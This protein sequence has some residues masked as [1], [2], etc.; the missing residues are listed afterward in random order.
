M[1]SPRTVRISHELTRRVGLMRA[2]FRTVVI[3]GLL[4][5]P[6]VCAATTMML[7]LDARDTVHGIQHAHLQ[8][9]VRSGPVTLSYPKWIPGE[10]A[11][12][13]A[14]TEVLNLRFRVGNRELPWRRDPRD[15]FTFHL[16][17]SQGAQH[18]DV[19]LDFYS[20]SQPFGAGFAKSPNATSKL[21]VLLFNQF[22]LYPSQQSTSSIRVV[23]RIR[24][25]DEW[26]YD[27]ALTGPHK[28]SGIIA[29]P[30]VSLTR[31]VDSPLLSARYLRTVAVTTGP[32]PTRLTIA[33][34]RASELE[35]SDTRIG[36]LRG[37][38]SETTS[39]FGGPHYD[40]YVWL[41][42]LS[43]GL[44]HD[45]TEHQDS[46]DIRES[47]K[48][49]QNP[50]CSVDIVLLPHEF[51]HSWNGKFRRPQDLMT[52][53]F[54][55]PMQDDLLW[56]YE[57]LTRYYGDFVLA[58]RSGLR[59]QQQAR[60][61]VAFVA[62]QMEIGRPGRAWRPLVDT[63]VTVPA[64]GDAPQAWTAARRGNDYYN[65]MLLIWLEADVLIRTQT[66]GNRS[67][68][69]FCR[70]FFASENRGYD[71]SDVIAAMN[72]TADYDWHGFFRQ[73]VY[74][75]APKAPLDG[76]MLGGWK[77]TF[78]DD[79]N[80]FLVSLEQISGTADFSSS[81][82]IW[83]GADGTVKDVVPA[84]PA[85]LAGIAPGSKILTV[86]SEV[87]STNG[88]RA[89]LMRAEKNPEELEMIVRRGTEE[90]C[91]KL[92]YGR[93]LRYPHLARN[94]EAKDALLQ[95]LSPHSPESQGATSNPP[96]EAGK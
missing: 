64:Y 11:P 24:L 31:L 87:F 20:P 81:L 94:D 4:M 92:R 72:A 75:L 6:T 19:D 46:S 93:G 84:S 63:A 16:R 30:T 15:A 53:N 28:V 42:A 51:V 34:D 38:V 61:Y 76:L 41:L 43:D 36:Q 88:E 69:D 80:P 74:E 23:S 66:K 44:T 90:Q 91:L 35:L 26:F 55:E 10:H 60:D 37:L 71:L 70:H 33:A 3:S 21:L 13:G 39:V 57:G 8:I 47:E 89:A 59:D 77:L 18:L 65:E 32:H 83:V 86:D 56:V 2:I 12:N 58:A 68:D 7:D 27:C 9:P 78:D 54:Q 52:K 95:I 79:P 45:G 48:L 29:L 62:A 50:G 17:A 85:F 82:G 96:T 25:P 67:L 5:P 22:V 49:F 40:Q 14:I 1:V 73:H